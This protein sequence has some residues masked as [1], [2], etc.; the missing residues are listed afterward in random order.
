MYSR[1]QVAALRDRLL[2]VARAPAVAAE[3]PAELRESV[4]AV[5]DDLK[6]AGWP[7]ERVVVAMKQ[8]AE[9]AGLSPSQKLIT[10]P[11]DHITERDAI[12]VDM[13]RWSIERYYDA[14]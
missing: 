6:T 4:Y 8:I 5:V 7:P 3:R 9:D 2:A 14:A 1:P 13:V 11:G 10:F 12:V